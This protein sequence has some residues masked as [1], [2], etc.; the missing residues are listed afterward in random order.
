[1]ADPSEAGVVQSSSMRVIEPGRKYRYGSKPTWEVVLDAVRQLGRPVSNTEVGDLIVETIPDFKRSNLA[2]DLSVLSVNCNSR[3]N[4]AV[5]HQ[6][7]RTDT[8]NRYDRLL[9]IVKGRDVRFTLYYPS[10]HGVWELADVGDKVLRPRF[11]ASADAGEMEQVRSAL[12]ADSN[13]DPGEDARRRVLAS[14]VRR[15]GQPAF[16]LALLDAYGRACAITGCNV[17]ALLEAAHIAPYRGTHTNQ[18]NNGLLLRADLHKLFDLHLFRIDPLARTVHL[19]PQ[20]RMSE[21]AML[22]GA[23]LRATADSAL[24]PWRDALAYHEERCGWMNASAGGAP[25]SE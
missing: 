18:V 2:A 5:N 13:W 4:H 23:V 12:E 1:M 25:L 10:I 15:E 6:P 19:S 20:L 3:G 21:Y 9:R 8:G 24:A 7:R 11:V 22:E 17:E 14:V 16:R